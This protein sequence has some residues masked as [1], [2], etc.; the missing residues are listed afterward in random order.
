M[1]TYCYQES[2][3]DHDVRELNRQIVLNWRARFRTLIDLILE[4]YEPR[5]NIDPDALA[6]MV[7][8]VIEGGLVLGRA[9]GERALLPNQL[10]LLRNYIR[11]LFEPGTSQ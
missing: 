4:R 2:L 3:F 6:D 7:S 5:D 8:T 1:A 9:T 11:L 10:M